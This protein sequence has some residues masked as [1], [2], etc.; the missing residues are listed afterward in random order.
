MILYDDKYN[1]LGMSSDTLSFLGYEDIGEFLSQHNDFANLFVNKEGYIYKF[2]N[3][4]WIDFVLYSGSTNKKAAVTLKNGQ[5]AEVS[6]SI[7]ELF[8]AQNLEGAKKLFSVKIISDN[9]NEISKT[10]RDTSNI[11]KSIGGFSLGG[12]IKK[13]QKTEEESLKEEEKSKFA[14]LIEE[15]KK[16]KE[17]SNDEGFI[18]NIADNELL[19]K[20]EIKLDAD[21]T[22]SNDGD[23]KLNFL[24]ANVSIEDEVEEEEPVLDLL[25]SEETEEEPVL[26][27]LKSEET[28]KE[29]VL[30]LLK[31]EETE[32]EPVLDLLKSDE[33]EEEPVLDLLKSD[34]VKEEPI[35]DEEKGNFKFNFPKNISN[36][37]VELN[38]LKNIDT[39]E[40][41]FNTV[42]ENKQEISKEPMIFNLLNENKKNDNI[43]E[44][45]DTLAFHLPDKDASKE[46]TKE[47]NND[48][49]FSFKKAKDPLSFLIDDDKESKTK[50]DLEP[51]QEKIESDIANK[52]TD[53]EISFLTTQK[54]SETFVNENIDFGLNSQTQTN[55]KKEGLKNKKEI[56]KQIK[57]DIKEIDAQPNVSELT[58]I[59]PIIQEQ[60]PIVN[61]LK[62]EEVKEEPVID[63]LKSEEVKED[64]E[65]K[66]FTSTLS[67]LFNNDEQESFEKVTESAKID[68][69]AQNFLNDEKKEDLENFNSLS[70]LS[71]L[72]LSADDEFYLMSDFISDTNESIV[73]MEEFIKTDS[74]DKINYPLIKIKSSAEILNLDAII[75]VSNRIR[76][77]CLDKNSENVVKNIQTLR[78]KIEF[79]EK[80][81][82]K[83][84]A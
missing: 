3:F 23:F 38:F 40:G 6:V 72:G 51:K 65:D 64:I 21:E 15:N 13:E 20:D 76:K 52:V 26:D 78:E 79:L 29:P 58:F 60:N 43:E 44:K 73:V 84:V 36:N 11:K 42:D 47:I 81:L 57:K 10:P 31:S 4:A 2:D 16:S 61:L 54:E 62:S 30:D 1:F 82:T 27:L 39:D 68:T 28:E 59:T 14:N 37:K 34:D 25:K 32:K 67:S 41:E 46:S 8:L 19:S 69:I 45:E 63:L 53:S 80:N 55:E 70:S 18:L 33:T 49:S 71:S 66:S 12:L 24:N 48:S 74:L 7:K 56:I 22:K 5:E 83:T 9:F 77:E 50:L 17:K 35:I 75:D